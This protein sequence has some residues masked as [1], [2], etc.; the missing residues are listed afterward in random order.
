[1]TLED[2]VIEL[3]EAMKVL[4]KSV[5]KLQQEMYRQDFWEPESPPVKQYKQTEAQNCEWLD[6]PGNQV[7]VRFDYTCVI[8]GEL[9]QGAVQMIPSGTPQPFGRLLTCPNGTDGEKTDPE[10]ITKVIFFRK[11]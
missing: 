5:L 1:V 6:C 3:E 2:K 11:R 8:C 10:H 7:H 4:A 9:I